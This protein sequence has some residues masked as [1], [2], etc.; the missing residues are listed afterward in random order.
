MAA[1]IGF[2]VDRFEKGIQPETHRRSFSVAT[3]TATLANADA[4]MGKE[5]C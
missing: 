3:S 5:R 4:V 1:V 2:R